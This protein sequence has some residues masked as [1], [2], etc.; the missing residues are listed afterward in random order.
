MSINQ[1]GTYLYGVSEE[2]L[3]TIAIDSTDGSIEVSS[4]LENSSWFRD[5]GIPVDYDEYFV[6]RLNHFRRLQL[7]FFLRT[8]SFLAIFVNHEEIQ[9]PHRQIGGT[10]P[11]L[12]SKVAITAITLQ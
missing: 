4:A 9:I 6:Q 5:A 12:K 2:Y 10:M 8:V 11:D 3:I 7:T 1:D